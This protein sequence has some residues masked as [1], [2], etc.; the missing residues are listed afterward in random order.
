MEKIIPR[1]KAKASMK[2]LEKPGKGEGLRTL[3]FLCSQI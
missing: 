2:C 3:L 1:A